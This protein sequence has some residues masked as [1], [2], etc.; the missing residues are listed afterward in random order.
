MN[1]CRAYPYQ[2][3]ALP[4]SFVW[5]SVSTIALLISVVVVVDDIERCDCLFGNVCAAVAERTTAVFN[6]AVVLAAVC[7]NRPFVAMVR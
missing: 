7:Y 1:F 5:N 3:S 4:F 2:P 6:T